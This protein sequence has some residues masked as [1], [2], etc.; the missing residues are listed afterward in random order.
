[1]IDDGT[2]MLYDVATDR[3]TPL[4]QGGQISQ[5]SW[6]GP[7]ELALVQTSGSSS[8]I[9]T[10]DTRSGASTDALIVSGRILAYGF[11]PQRSSI[12]TLIYD[13]REDLVE[14]SVHYLVGD[15][16]VLR[17]GSTEL[18]GRD[19]TLDAGFAATFS[20]DGDRVLFLQTETRDG[21]GAS[22][23]LQVRGRDG[24]LE[25]SVDADRAPTAATWL[26]DGS[27]TFRSRD[28]V[29]RWEPG[30][31]SSEAVPGLSTWYA[32]WPA[33]NAKLVAYDTGRTSA[34][35]RVRTVH[36]GN[37]KVRD[38]GPAG[39]ANPVF[40][41]YD[42]IWVQ[43][44]QRCSPGCAQPYVLGPVVS[45]VDITTGRERRLQLP[46]LEGLAL[47]SEVPTVGG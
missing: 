2:V 11:D 41:R 19:G 30:D 16:A 46:T 7:T 18:V 47:W 29:R 26:P 14:A 6:V 21:E 32:P 24:A 45:A 20:P 5:L 33:P 31:S 23:P 28:G 25:Y 9:R 15:R 4:V 44:V 27:L 8:S 17:A 37:G 36:L 3:V 35:V 10:I 38:V 34:D 42:E 39:R 13:E 1:M 43:I 22:A 40:A 12:A